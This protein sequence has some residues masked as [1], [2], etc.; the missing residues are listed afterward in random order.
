MSQQYPQQPGYGYPQQPGQP[1]QGWA[2]PG[3]PQQQWGAPPQPPKKSST[4]KKIGIGCLGAVAA[5][6]ILGAVGSAMSGPDDSAKDTS[7][8]DKAV[9][10]ASST[11]KTGKPKEA[12][13]KEQPAEDTK[14]QAEQFQACVAKSGTA[15]E[16][17]AVKHVTKV[18]GADKRND[19]L[20]SAEVYTD[21][22]GGIMSANQ[23]DAKLIAS[24]FTS[25]YESKN[26]L[27][28]VYGAD[29][30]LMANANY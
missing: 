19:I 7:N 17:A 16:K 26:G 22:K 9:A 27:V 14:S 28:S 29:G 24:A 2:G 25:C 11:P 3:A 23:G 15:S 21:Y 5:L 4:G 10:A 30:D 18:T 13:A 8:K 1:Q 20:D 6:V 12:P